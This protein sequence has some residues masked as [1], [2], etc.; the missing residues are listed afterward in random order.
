M[1]SAFLWLPLV[2]IIGGMV[3]YYGPAEELRSRQ[4]QEKVTHEKKTTEKSP[5]W[6]WV[7]YTIGE[8]SRSGQQAS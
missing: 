1:K 6:I 3:G 4:A 5:A 8:H 7:F 2:F